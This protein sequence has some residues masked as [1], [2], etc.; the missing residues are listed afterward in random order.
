ME[1]YRK[2]VWKSNQLCS[3]SGLVTK[4]VAA[5]D[6][7]NVRGKAVLVFS[8]VALSQFM[9]KHTDLSSHSFSAYAAQ[10]RSSA[11]FP[12]SLAVLLVRNAF[13]FL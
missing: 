13:I 5:Y 6:D 10:R 7:E 3:P 1:N 12:P 8:H 9:H 2:L 11:H 4:A